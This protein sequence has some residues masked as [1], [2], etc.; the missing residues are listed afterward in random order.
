MDE[1]QLQQIIDD[2]GV[3]YRR[4][5]KRSN[6][7]YSSYSYKEASTVMMFANEIANFR[8]EIAWRMPTGPHPAL[9]GYCFV[10]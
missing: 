4:A 5:L 2:L 10:G 9:D 7:L 6:Q 3:M 1:G 8:S